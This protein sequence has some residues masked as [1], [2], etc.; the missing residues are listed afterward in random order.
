MHVYINTTVYLPQSSY[1]FPCA[2]HRLQ[3][4]LLVFLPKNH[5]FFTMLFSIEI[6][7]IDYKMYTVLCSLQ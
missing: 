6:C 1:M 2:T 7:F 3:V 5:T 4:G